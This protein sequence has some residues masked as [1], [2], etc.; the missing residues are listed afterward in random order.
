MSLFSKQKTDRVMVAQQTGKIVPITEVPDDVFS[1]KILG[2]GVGIIPSD[3]RVL[4]PISGKIV[5]IADTLH[6]ICIESDDGLEI[7]I[8][9]GLDTV[10]LK[11][12]GFTCHVKV[13]QHVLTGDLLMDM[14]IEQIKQAGYRVVTPCIITNMDHVKKLTVYGGSADAGKTAIM[15]Y[16]L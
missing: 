9:L 6:A 2:N 8:H 4:A 7:L 15:K 13:G 3:H 5:Q 1:G 16:S 10:Q 11:G 12:Q 14:D